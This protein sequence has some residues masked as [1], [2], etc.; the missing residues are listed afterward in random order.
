VPG[1]GDEMQMEGDSRFI[2][3]MNGS[4]FEMKKLL[5]PESRLKAAPTIWLI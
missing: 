1:K 2:W 3:R 4:W 5:H